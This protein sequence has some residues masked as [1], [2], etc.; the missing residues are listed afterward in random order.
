M[1]TPWSLTPGSSCMVSR[2]QCGLTSV[3]YHLQDCQKGFF[4]V[5]GALQKCRGILI[6]GSDEYLFLSKFDQVLL[7]H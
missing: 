1:G 3:C 4:W 2:V 5:V 7:C 6:A